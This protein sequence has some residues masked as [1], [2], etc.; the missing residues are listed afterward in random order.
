MALATVVYAAFAKIS[1]HEEQSPLEEKPLQT[2][3]RLIL[4]IHVTQVV[5]RTDLFAPTR[6][7]RISFPVRRRIA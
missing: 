6:I 3:R 1:P 7:V 5:V 4:Y 2:M